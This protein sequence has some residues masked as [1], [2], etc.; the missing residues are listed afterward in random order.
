[1]DVAFGLRE[2]HWV[3]AL[4]SVPFRF[5]SVMK[6]LVG[7]LLTNGGK[8]D[9]CTWRRTGKRFRHER[10]YQDK[11]RTISRVL[12]KISWTAV[13]LI[14][15]VAACSWALF[16]HNWSII[17]HSPEV[18]QPEE[19][20]QERRIHYRVSTYKGDVRPQ[21]D[22]NLK[23]RSYSTNWAEFFI[24]RSWT[25]FSAYDNKVNDRP[26]SNKGEAY[27]MG[28]NFTTEND[29]CCQIAAVEGSVKVNQRW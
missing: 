22:K 1:M 9:V 10:E 2:L 11:V 4:S 23:R 13:E 27:L 26:I 29:G 17:V 15:A 24:C 25:A 3:H 7:H 20:S 14:R 19:P 21:W 28:R 12:L 18:D 16:E 5:R 6:G 8:H